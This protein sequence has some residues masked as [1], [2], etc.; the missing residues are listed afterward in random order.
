M[1]AAPEDV[2]TERQRA[3]FA[4]LREGLERD[5]GK[6]LDEWVAIA[7]TCPETKHRARLNWFK[8]THGLAQNRASLV[9]STAF[10]PES[11][12]DEPEALA[13]ALWIDPIARALLDAVKAAMAEL[14]DVIIGQR[15]AFTAFSRNY[16]FAAAR[17]QGSSL[18][19]GLAVPPDAAPTLEPPARAS[20]SDR[21][22]SQAQISANADIAPLKGAI[23]RAWE[24]S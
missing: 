10:P 13:D 4:S 2:L 8:T 12:W 20:W 16:Q 22:K 21:L 23:R 9:L 19:L 14:P 7:K 15:K 6:T 24:A 11:G 18:V 17:P 5:T 3:W 1:P